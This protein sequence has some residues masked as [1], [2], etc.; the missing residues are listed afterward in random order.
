MKRPSRRSEPGPGGTFLEH[1]QYDENG[2]F[3]GASLADYLTPTVTD[4]PN[5][6]TLVLE[7]SRSPNNP[8]LSPPAIGRLVRDAEGA[9]R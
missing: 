9:G 5:I 4:F 3:L 1:L 6:R 7:N 8:P 2:Q